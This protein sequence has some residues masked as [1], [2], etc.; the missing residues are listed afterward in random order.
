MVTLSTD[1]LEPVVDLPELRRRKDDFEYALAEEHSK[2][3]IM[4]GS[5]F[6]SAHLADMFSE[7]TQDGYDNVLVVLPLGIYSKM[8]VAVGDASIK[9]RVISE[10]ENEA[11]VGDVW[12]V[13]VLVTAEEPGVV[14][15][16]GECD[17]EVRI[18]RARA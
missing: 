2:E 10:L 18:L 1:F 16:L 17:G 9:L 12:G 14:Q 8:L 6:G 5:Y 7:N 3:F 11:M 13:P 15:V 4:E